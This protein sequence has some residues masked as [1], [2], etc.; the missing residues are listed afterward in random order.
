LELG[1]FQNLAISGTTLENNGAN[2]GCF[3]YLEIDSDTRLITCN[4]GTNDVGLSL[5]LGSFGD[6]TNATFYGALKIVTEGLITNHP[7]A[8]IFFY[9]IQQ[10]DYLGGGQ[11]A[12]M[13]NS[14]GNTV[15]QFNDAI[16]IMCRKASIPVIDLY[17]DWGVSLQ[18]IDSF[19]YDRL[20]P[21]TAGHNRRATVIINKIKQYGL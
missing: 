13:T 18:N 11:M 19:T 4:Y 21:N 8:R 2:S 6:T 20:H 9:T 3:K 17:Q 7:L 16:K 14:N 15:E 12:G 5:P 10:R 1:D